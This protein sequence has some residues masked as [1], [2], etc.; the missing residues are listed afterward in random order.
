MRG[1]VYRWRPY[2]RRVNWDCKGFMRNKPSFKNNLYVF[3]W[4]KVHMIYRVTWLAKTAPLPH[5]YV[6]QNPAAV[7]RFLTK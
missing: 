2:F 6:F 5:F 1:E 4:G 7:L 3:M